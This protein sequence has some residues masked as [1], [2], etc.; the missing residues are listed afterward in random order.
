M[1]T[2]KF[3]ENPANGMI[4]EAIPGL[5]Y[6]YDKGTNCWV[7][8]DGVDSLGLAT[9]LADGLMSKED[10]NKL[11]DLI[12][13]P[14]QA[15]IKGEEC[16]TKFSS[17]TV[18]LESDDDFLNIDKDLSLTNRGSNFLI[19]Q[20]QAW[21]LHR[22]TAGYDFTISIEDLIEEIENRSQLNRVQ[23]QGD[24][25]PQGEQGDD[26]IDFL[27]TGPKGDKGSAGQNSAFVGALVPETLSLEKTDNSN[28]AIVDIT[29][30]ESDDGNYLVV[31]R[32]NIGNPDACPAQIIPTSFN[33][34]LLVVIKP[35]TSLIRNEVINSGE[36]SLV[37]RICASSLYH[38]NIGPIVN[39]INQKYQD[40]IQRLKTSKEEL[41]KIWLTAMVEL[42]N[43]QKAS[44]CCALE[45]CL[46][47][48]R[49]QDTRRY[50]ETQA[51]QAAQGGFH[52]VVDGKDQRQTTDMDKFKD[53][54][55]PTP[56]SQNVALKDNGIVFTL[57]ARIHTG[58]PRSEPANRSLKAYLPAGTYSLEITGCCANFNASS[59]G[60]QYSGRVA[61]LYRAVTTL[62]DVNR[63]ETEALAFPA[64]GEFSNLS[65]AKN[66]YQGIVL[67]FEHAGGE[68]SAWLLDPDKFPEN[69]SG[70]VELCVELVPEASELFPT[71]TEIV[72]SYRN[73]ISSDTNLGRITTF[74]GSESP[75]ANFGK[76]GSNINLVNGPELGETELS[77]FLY[78]TTG[79]LYYYL[80][81]GNN[82]TTLDTSINLEIEITSNPLNAGIIDTTSGVD[83][84]QFVSNTFVV[85]ID[86]DGTPEG[87][88]LGPIDPES[89][90]I[91]SIT[92]VDLDALQSWTFNGV[93]NTITILENS[94]GIGITFSSDENNTIKL[95]SVSDVPTGQF[96]GPGGLLVQN[97]LEGPNNATD[98]PVSVR[99]SVYLTRPVSIEVI[100]SRTVSEEGAVDLAED[101]APKPVNPADVADPSIESA[102][103]SLPP[104]T[105]PDPTKPPSSSLCDFENTGVTNSGI[106]GFGGGIISASGDESLDAE[107]VV[108][109][110]V[111]ASETSISRDT[112][113]AQ[114]SGIIT[115]SGSVK[116]NSLLSMRYI[117]TDSDGNKYYSD[118]VTVP[119]NPNNVDSW[120]FFD[121]GP[122]VSILAPPEEFTVET[123]SLQTLDVN[124]VADKL[125][126]SQVKRAESLEG[127]SRL[128]YVQSILGE[129][130]DEVADAN[131]MVNFEI[132]IQQMNSNEE[133]RFGNLNAT[134]GSDLGR[135]LVY[136]IDDFEYEPPIV[137]PETVVVNGSIKRTI[138]KI[139]GSGKT[140]VFNG[141]TSHYAD[142]GQAARLNYYNEDSPT[143]DISGLKFFTL[144][145]V[146]DNLITQATSKRGF[147]RLPID[148]NQRLYGASN[149]DLNSNG[150][151]AGSSSGRAMLVDNYGILI[152]Y[153]HIKGKVIM[154]GNRTMLSRI[155]YGDLSDLSS[156]NI[157]LTCLGA[158]VG[159]P[160]PTSD[161]PA[162]MAFGEYFVTPQQKHRPA[163]SIYQRIFVSVGPN[164]YSFNSVYYQMMDSWQEWQLLH[165]GYTIPELLT[166]T[167]LTP[168]DGIGNQ[169]GSPLTLGQSVAVFQIQRMFGIANLAQLY[170]EPMIQWDLIGEP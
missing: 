114:D 52:L 161:Y 143:F 145:E 28:R 83:V 79:G 22:N 72:Y 24:T 123:R 167:P 65:A 134:V 100:N 21:Q 80:I 157:G 129:S 168:N 8:I 153:D 127:I 170:L 86:I 59:G 26:G 36:C 1:T 42:F 159:V 89:D 9:P 107:S 30:E 135:N 53:C 146:G 4:F 14:P 124:L 88:I 29:T 96:G 148:T 81:A 20:Q 118:Y 5:F 64:L 154:Y 147:K 99:Q 162:S 126:K 50:I 32:A 160:V 19:S 117:F 97:L 60:N 115:V 149:D 119:E 58:D 35:G 133:L 78:N 151:L 10:F 77:T 55:I 131:N 120:N 37:C 92:P 49:N 113:I 61:I 137:E 23:L 57:D 142:Y 47:R 43:E 85:N 84:K 16:N 93:E 25:G 75:I 122:P 121:F 74:S 67:T 108:S 51:I 40:R 82:T 101:I 106:V 110:S 164:I 125:T 46:S 105:P 17:G 66:A 33:S 111:A 141:L 136:T 166:G 34:N 73:N 41:L 158:E 139:N 2:V 155:L 91:I 98:G 27:D 48:N 87:L 12:L 76:S 68:V 163:S 94:A 71:G 13:P 144:N 102:T 54:P 62:N 165:R 70:S 130:I 112:I 90:Y 169:P 132:E 103:V 45:N 15:T 7:R 150:V 44:L 138:T 109:E 69:N 31:T 128:T 140:T 56:T 116:S 18:A 11:Q 38:L 95:F 39:A 104:T 63:V 152:T 6:Q 3:P 156:F